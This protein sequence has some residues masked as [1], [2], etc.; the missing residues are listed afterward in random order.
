MVV[1]SEHP[2]YHGAVLEPV[3]HLERGAGCEPMRIAQ[4][5]VRGGA[6]IRM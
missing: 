6:I 2:D 3:W 1:A 5:I 4:L